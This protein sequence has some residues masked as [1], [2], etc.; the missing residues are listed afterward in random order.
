MKHSFWMNKPVYV[1]QKQIN[2]C[3]QILTNDELLKYISNELENTRIKLNYSIKNLNQ[4]SETEQYKILNFINANYISSTDNDFKLLYSLDLLK[5]Y[6]DN[7]L[8]IE[9]YPKSNSYNNVVGYIIG[10]SHETIIDQKNINCLEVNFLCIIPELRNLGLSGFMINTLTKESILNYNISVAHYTIFSEIKSPHFSKKKIYYRII[11]I[12][13][14]LNTG[15]INNDANIPLYKKI[16][17]TFSYRKNNTNIV[18][19]NGNDHENVND[20]FIDTL[21]NRYIEYA[22]NTYDIYNYISFEDFKKTFYNKSF[23][24]FIIYNNSGEIVAYVCMFNINILNTH[25]NLTYNSGYL[26]NMFFE[27]QIEDTLEY[28][29]EYIYNNDIFDVITFTDIFYFDYNNIKCIP[30]SGYL[31]YYLFNSKVK[32]I[33]NYKNG[34]ITI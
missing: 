19:I 3:E 24:H 21:Y 31:H 5:Y 14:L 34:L 28:I 9:F 32:K 17:N 11:N 4:L 16:Y 30:G 12:P 33:E 23:H 29:H 27:I 20:H 1:E 25:T 6:A 18:Y 7:A 15:F 13:K 26:Y 2:K 8:L 22:H 10:K